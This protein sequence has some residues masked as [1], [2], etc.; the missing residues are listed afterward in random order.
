ML[1]QQRDHI[2]ALLREAGDRR[3]GV[4]A[5]LSHLTDA[6][7]SQ[8]I[9]L[10]SDLR[11][12]SEEQLWRLEDEIRHLQLKM[13]EFLSQEA[14]ISSVVEKIMVQQSRRGSGA[15]SSD[16]EWRS[17]GYIGAVKAALDSSSSHP[18]VPSLVISG[19][20]KGFEEE[21]REEDDI[22]GEIQSISNK[23]RDRLAHANVH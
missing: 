21:R 13:D 12:D 18:Q 9:W 16:E 2:G 19:A 5:Q 20:L 7:L 4:Q 10:L 11:R 1:L 17:V 3:G 15:T 8:S 6:V 23:I 22:C 14:A